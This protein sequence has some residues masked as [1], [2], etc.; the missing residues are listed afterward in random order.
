M[1]KADEMFENLG[2]K[3]DDD[4][5]RIV[6]YD[7]NIADVKIYKVVFNKNAEG[8]FRLKIYEQYMDLKMLQ[9]I[10][11]KVKELRLDRRRR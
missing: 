10:N 11:E 3:I 8:K 9:A 7:T 1:S 5:D 2:L 4:E 6:I